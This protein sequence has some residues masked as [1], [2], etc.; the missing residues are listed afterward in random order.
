MSSDPETSSPNTFVTGNDSQE[1]P[2]HPSPESCSNVDALIESSNRLKEE[3][4]ENF[5]LS[6]WEDALDRYRL[7]LRE[8]PNRRESE[9]AQGDSRVTSEAEPLHLPPTNSDSGAQARAVLNGNI[10]ACHF[11]QSDFSEA[12]KACTEALL[13]N[14]DYIK[15][16]KRRAECNEKIG[17]WTSLTQAQSDLKH[18]LTLLP[19]T[20]PLRKDT[21]RQLARVEPLLAKAQKAETDEMLNKLKD[22]GNN[23]L[24]NFGLSTNNFNFEPNGQGGYS[25]Q[26][27]R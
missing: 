10:A 19:G 25:M 22:L 5:R 23:V 4:N 18:L 8:L 20:D 11:R 12:A 13:D 1:S 24:G 21:T 16:L 2:P 14:P 15:V 17:T 3:G 9:A 26:F 27:Q 7:A 6:R